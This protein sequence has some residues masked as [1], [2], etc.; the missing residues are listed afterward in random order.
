MAVPEF[1]DLTALIRGLAST[2]PPLASL[3]AGIVQMIAARLPYYNWVGFYMLDPHDPRM[4]TLGPF[5]GEPTPHVRIP[6]DQGICGAAVAG[7]ETIV[8][9]DVNTDARY[10]ACSIQTRSE[11]VVPI[12]VGGRVVGEIDVDS[13][14]PAAFQDA[15]RKFLESVARIVGDSMALSQT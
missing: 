5:S 7:R 6:V 11:I 10:L 4:L 1:D 9:D 14:T 12:F 3:Q 15:D 13:H 2:A 8:V